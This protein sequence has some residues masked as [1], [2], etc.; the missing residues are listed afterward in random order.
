M[1][2]SNILILITGI[3]VMYV[4]LIQF[5]VEKEK[6][7][8][9]DKIEWGIFNK[10]LQRA[11]Y[12]RA[13]H[14]NVSASERAKISTDQFFDSVP[15]GKCSALNTSS[16][17]DSDSH[18]IVEEFSLIYSLNALCL[19]LRFHKKTSNTVQFT[20][21]DS[22]DWYAY[23]YLRLLNPLYV[24][25]NANNSTMSTIG[26]SIKNDNTFI[27]NSY[28]MGHYNVAGGKTNYNNV[29][30]DLQPI[31]L[32]SEQASTA[33]LSK[34]DYI[35][36]LRLFTYPNYSQRTLDSLNFGKTF[37]TA[38]E[39]SSKY[40]NLRAYYIDD[41]PVSSQNV[42]S[43]LKYTRASDGKYKVYDKNF[44]QINDNKALKEKFRSISETDINNV[45]N[46]CKFIMKYHGSLERNEH[47]VFTVSFDLNMT[48]STITSLKPTPN[49]NN[50]VLEL[51]MNNRLGAQKSCGNNYGTLGTFNMNGNILSAALMYQ[52]N[53]KETVLRFCTSRNGNCLFS[54]PKDV[55]DIKLPILE[56][57]SLGK[58][59]V[60][61]TPYT[62]IV[63]VTWTSKG[64]GLQWVF[65]QKK[66]DS[67]NDFER[68]FIGPV[69]EN[70]YLDDIIINSSL[71]FVPQ[72]TEM[73][74]GY[75][76]FAKYVKKSIYI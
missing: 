68:L 1:R 33:A 49:T 69:N 14:S 74:L 32:P 55:L 19:A 53:M 36:P 17:V 65:A 46:M 37:F 31:Q 34:Q 47:P 48:Q 52:A 9:D 18:S 44:L 40:L 24:E 51:F 25:F 11:L 6:F 42:A 35:E 38:D 76:N 67:G 15:K 23:A 66:V 63:L 50:M 16:K 43:Y 28:G 57:S 71:D 5:S 73:K 60:T 8:A 61:V 7:S 4:V 62:I 30:L 20:V 59:I 29:R 54:N 70:N 75:V 72:V 21:K 13:P 41:V 2:L 10:K 58:V 26:Y 3:L 12:F 45:R 64:N 22:N 39:D 56:N 27:I